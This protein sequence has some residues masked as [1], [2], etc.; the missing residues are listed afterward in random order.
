MRALSILVLF[1]ATVPSYANET[2]WLEAETFGPLKGANFS[3]MPTDRT[4]KGSWSLAGP[5]AAASWTQGGE[6][7][8]MSIA[9][10]ADEAAPLVAGRDSEV[11]VDGEYTLW[12]RYADYRGKQERFG[13][14]V[15][16]GAATIERTFGEKPIIDELDPMKLLWDWSFA[17]DRSTVPLRKGPVRVELFTSGP[18]GARRCVDVLCFTTDQAYR[19]T[20]RE[21]LDHPTWSLLRSMRATHEDKAAASF[22]AIENR[23]SK[24][25]NR[26]PPTFLWNTGPPWGEELKKP[27]AD[28]IDAPFG[29]D[30]PLL[31][32]FLATF[33]GKSPPIYSS[34]LS[35][36]V[37]HIPLYP[38]VFTEGSPF[39]DWLE[40]YPDRRFAILLNYGEPSWPVDKDKSADRAA[41]R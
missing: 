12:V 40:R 26:P 20:G 21:K 34:K 13:I 32:D 5:D 29:V 1:C 17:W 39:L 28:R 8:W 33:K 36:P 25:E 37:W 11:A 18:T 23:K 10:R 27:L 4:T 14:R 38:Q 15:K 16:Q 41:I 31:N 35:G 24:I 30:P 3:F 2:L 19:P 22:A 6:S 7:E 9:C